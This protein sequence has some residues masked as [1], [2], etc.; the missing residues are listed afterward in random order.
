MT[1]KASQLA[2]FAADLRIG[3]GALSHAACRLILDTVAVGWAGVDAP[4]VA[5]LRQ[6]AHATAGRAEA[7]LWGAA[8][9]LPAP[10]AAFVNGAAAAA[11]DF[12]AVH[13]GSILHADAVVLPAALAIAE[14]EGRSGAELLSAYIAGIE[15]AHRLSMATPR[16]GGWFGTSTAGVF[17]AAAAAARL[18]GLDRDGIHHAM[19]IALSLSGGT[20]QAIVER[21]LTKRLQS[22][23]V[24]RSGIHAAYAAAAGVSGP[25]DWLEGDFGWF[26]LYEP[27]DANQVVEQLG[28]R[29][30]F[31]NTGIKKF[32]SCL[33]NHAVIDAAQSLMAQHRLTPSD[34]DAIDVTISPYMYGIVGAAFDPSGD[35]QVAA[36]FSVQYA[37]AS[38]VHRGNLTLA[39]IEPNK[40]RDTE[41]G[42]LVRAVK[43]HVESE[44]PGQ[45]APGKVTL[46][47]R[48]QKRLTHLVDKLPGS[49]ARPLDDREVIE[50]AVSCFTTGSQPMSRVQAEALAGRLL[51]LSELPDVGSL[52][53][54]E[55]CR[56]TA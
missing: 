25:R 32:P 16:R 52:F 49:A 11:L 41:F 18:L 30:D 7:S 48:H 17:G 33:C 12:D 53:M 42:R 10:E 24:A 27:G 34:V 8:G 13:E 23:F 3:G 19:G 20:K 51:S 37:A 14:R 55:A 44:W 5:P 31:V 26:A 4:G 46:T 9:K 45:V 35:A 38:A 40:V 1:Q 43:V 56:K 29:F 50:K 39:D 21:T 6:L 47:T 54:E 36:Q 28:S 22:A 2:E 15:I